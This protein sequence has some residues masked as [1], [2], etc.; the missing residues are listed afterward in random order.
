MPIKTFILKA[1]QNV[2]RS[3]CI[4]LLTWFV[5]ENVYLIQA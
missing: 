1:K 4:Y 2:H 3:L 5:F